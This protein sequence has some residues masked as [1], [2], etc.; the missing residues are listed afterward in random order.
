[1]IDQLRSKWSGKSF[2]TYML[3]TKKAV[4]A[5]RRSQ[6]KVF[7]H[8]K[9]QNQQEKFNVYSHL[10]SGILAAIGLIILLIE[11]TPG[12]GYFLTIWV[13]GFSLMFVFFAS[14][15]WHMHKKS[16]DEFSRWTLVDEISIFVAIAGAFT[17]IAVFYLEGTLRE[18]TIG[19]QWGSA[20][21]G[22]LMKLKYTMIK[23]WKTAII[24][25]TMGWGGAIP[26]QFAFG[27][28]DPL[29]IV[30]LFGCGIFSSIGAVLFATR[31]PKHFHEIFHVLVTFALLFHYISVISFISH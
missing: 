14:S 9:I 16:E 12:E 19:F 17:P 28:M 26:I 18:I 27:Q 5:A 8:F 4:Q 15:F 23:R 13:Y 21:V 10:L 30:L 7:P 31:K 24:Y 29:T 20:L 25:L 6:T 22:I 1:M 3:P 2:Q 11:A